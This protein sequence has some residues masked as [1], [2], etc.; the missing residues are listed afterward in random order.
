MDLALEVVTEVVIEVV[1][2]SAVRLDMVRT[3]RRLSPTRA[4]QVETFLRLEWRPTA[5]AEAVGCHIS[6]IYRIQESLIRYEAR[7]PPQTVTMGATRALTKY[8]EDALLNWLRREP[9][10]QQ[11]EM[12][13]FFW[14]EFDLEVSQSTVSRT[15]SRRGWSRGV[16]YRLSNRADAELVQWWEIHMAQLVAEQLVFVDESSFNR[17][18]GWRLYTYRPIGEDARYQASR[19]RGPS[20][21]ILPAYTIEGYIACGVKQGYYNRDEFLEFISSQVL[22]QMNPFPGYRSVLV[23]DN[24]SIHVHEIVVELCETY[25]VRLLYLP[26]YSPRYNP[27][28]LTFSVLKS[29]IRR[30]F[31]RLFIAFRNDF[32]AFLRFALQHSRCDQHARAHF[33]NTPNGGYIYE[34]NIEAFEQELR[35]AEAEWLDRCQDIVDEATEYLEHEE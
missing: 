14:E 2:A 20:Y 24:A 12:V 31:G 15:L 21:S 16:A 26:P 32:E 34:A 29:W 23:M 1:T 28:E 25:G 30:N 33:K 8:E 10:S 11:Q 3:G 5:I 27:I 18:T 7:Y 35:E 22:P 4:S 17:Q 19:D 13:Q 9:F 6:T